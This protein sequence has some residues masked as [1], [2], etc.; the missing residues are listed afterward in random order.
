MEHIEVIGIAGNIYLLINKKDLENP[1]A[2]AVSVL[3]NFIDEQA[4]FYTYD[5]IG[6]PLTFNAFYEVNQED[7][8][9]V[10]LILKQRLSQKSQDAI[11]SF[12]N[13]ENAV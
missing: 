3:C 8:A 13:Q 7:R 12:L 10:L 9:N 2:K 4:S 6:T 11:V 1:N 5:I